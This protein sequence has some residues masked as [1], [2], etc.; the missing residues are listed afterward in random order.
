[1]K[2]FGHLL[3]LPVDRDTH[4]IFHRIQINVFDSAKSRGTSKWWYIEMHHVRTLFSV[5]RHGFFVLRDVHSQRVYLHE[6]SLP[7]FLSAIELSA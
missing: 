3:P 1:M 5:W 2:K 7:Y 4:E 6:E